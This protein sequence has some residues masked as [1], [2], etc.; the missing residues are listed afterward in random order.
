M[1]ANDWMG[2]AAEWRYALLD[3]AL[4]T[5]LKGNS[6]ET[7]EA[8]A[9]RAAV[10]WGRSRL[11]GVPLGDWDGVLVVPIARAGARWLRW[12]L[13]VLRKRADHLP[14]YWDKSDDD[15]EARDECLSVLEE[16]MDAWAAFV[17]LDESQIDA[18]ANS[19]DGREELAQEC[20]KAQEELCLADEALIRQ[21]EI[22]SVAAGTELLYNWLRLLVEPYRLSLPWWLDGCL[23]ATANQLWKQLPAQRVPARP[24]N[25]TA[26]IAERQRAREV[27]PTGA[28]MTL[29]ISHT[30]P[31]LKSSVGDAMKLLDRNEDLLELESRIGRFNIFDA[32]RIAR[33]EIRHS[34]FLAFLLDP[35]ES[36]GQG[37]LFLK[38]LLTDLL[39]QS[40]LRS[41]SP[42]ELDGTDLRGVVVEREW[43]NIDLLIRCKEPRFAVVIENKIDSQERS[44]QLS[45]YQQTMVESYPKLPTLYVYLTPDGD[46][47]S[48]E[49]W[50][51]YT[52]ER[53]YRVFDRVV[54]TYHNTIGAEVRVFLDHYL[55]LLGTRFMND[56]K[57]DDLCRRIYNNH[58]QA[59]D[60]IWERVGNP[61]SGPLA[62]VEYILKQDQRW[63]VLHITKR[64]VECVPK[65]WQEW[66]SP[67][68]SDNSFPFSVVLKVNED[69]LVVSLWV[70]PIK[71]DQRRTEVIN[72]LRVKSPNF[73]FRP[74]RAKNIDNDWDQVTGW[75]S[76]LAWDEDEPDMDVLREGLKKKLDELYAR[77]EKLG[78]VMRPLLEQTPSGT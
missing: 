17:A 71:N 58:R 10:A 70:G 16:R 29:S 52:Y 77:L 60:L 63:Q 75:E 76:I 5:C 78:P 25:G 48:E 73:E 35:A 27:L 9:Y 62:A 64:R 23:E 66:L 47:P 49:T 38:A 14:T 46:E 55:N 13:Q 21:K 53:I 7:G 69:G 22:L 40:L 56:E 43:K 36:H 57:L 12:C 6:N 4:E 19:L 26:D 42:I 74:T 44:G 61:L 65:D 20:Q 37:Q 68:E 32:L 67:Y 18:L 24:V 72:A 31:N 34:N 30:Q 51:P 1:I 45:R 3:P 50:V 8:A 54:R 11:F 28:S 59:L 2:V 33:A 39:T 41:L 15:I